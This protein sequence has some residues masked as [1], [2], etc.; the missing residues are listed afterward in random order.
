MPVFKLKMVTYTCALSLF[1]CTAFR[2]FFSSNVVRPKFM[3]P[4]PLPIFPCHVFKGTVARLSVTPARVFFLGPN[5]SRG[6][7]IFFL[8]G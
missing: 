1:P 8:V 5:S 2:P 4:L 6:T 7:I 3:T